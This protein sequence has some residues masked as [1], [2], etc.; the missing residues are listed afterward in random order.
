MI[1]S[2][3]IDF[4]ELCRQDSLNGC[5]SKCRGFLEIQ[6]FKNE[7]H[8]HFEEFIRRKKLKHMKIE[9]NNISLEKASC[10]NSFANLNSA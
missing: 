4:C 8:K 10:Y 6:L 3:I 2:A 5:S 7:L 9:T 1:Y